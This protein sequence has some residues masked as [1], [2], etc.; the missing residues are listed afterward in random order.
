M[1]TPGEMERMPLRKAWNLAALQLPVPPSHR[2]LEIRGVVRFGRGLPGDLCFC[3]RDPG[4]GFALPAGVVVLCTEELAPK[5]RALQP[6]AVLLPAADPRAAFIDA[7]VRLLEQDAVE[8]TSLLPRPW[9]THPS[10]RIGAGTVVHPE[11]RIDAGAVIGANCVIHRGSWIG[12]GAI[13]RD[14]TVI[15][16]D[17]INAYRGKDG[18]VRSFPH[19]AGVLVGQRTQIGAN[20]VVVRGIVDSTRIGADCVIG[21]LCNIGHVVEIGDG[22]WM[23]VGCLVGGHT[24]IGAGATL[25]M[26]VSVKDNL[27]IGEKAQVGMGSV[28]VKSV[29]PASSVFGNPA[30][31]MGAIQAGPAR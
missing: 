27:E 13:L 6:E 14:H 11:S 29:A 30:R 18:Q 23:S 10:A 24:R 16:C 12:A 7:G 21:N 1:V 8:A 31:F 15:G 3:D 26:G 19:F 25:G 5:L 17:G 20:A 9:G 4:E 28:V 22:A 2:S